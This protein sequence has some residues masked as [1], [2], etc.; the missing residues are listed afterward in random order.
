[1]IARYLKPFADPTWY[2]LHGTVQL[3][4]YVVGT[5]G[6]AYG[7]KLMSDNYKH[8]RFAFAVFALGTVQVWFPH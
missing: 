3:V 7:I 1:M 6:F 2:Y 5:V 8:R 4:G